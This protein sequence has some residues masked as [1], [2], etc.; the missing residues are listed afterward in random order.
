[1]VGEN[2]IIEISLWVVHK[3]SV[4]G[5]MQQIS[6]LCAKLI[7]HHGH[8]SRDKSCLQTTRHSIWITIYTQKPIRAIFKTIIGKY[9][10]GKHRVWLWWRLVCFWCFRDWHTLY[11]MHH[12]D[13]LVQE[14]RYSSA[15]AIELRLSCTYPS[16]DVYGHSI[17]LQTWYDLRAYIPVW[18]L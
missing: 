7:Y 18:K 16:T 14:I 11:S 2:R 9:I 12:V 5:L 1:M 8:F 17:V 4:Y 3:N 13:R 6:R 10:P 15:L